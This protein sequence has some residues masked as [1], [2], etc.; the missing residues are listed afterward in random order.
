MFILVKQKLD[1]DNFFSNQSYECHTQKLTVLVVE[2]RMCPLDEDSG[3]ATNM[4]AKGNLSFLAFSSCPPS[5]S[6]AWCPERWERASGF[7][8]FTVKQ[9]LCT[10]V[11][12]LPALCFLATYLSTSILLISGN[13]KTVKFFHPPFQNKFPSD[14]L[15]ETP[16]SRCSPSPSTL[17]EFPN[18]QDLI[19]AAETS[20]VFCL[21]L[22]RPNPAPDSSPH[23]SRV[24]PSLSRTR[25]FSPSLSPGLLL[26]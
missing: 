6:C 14:T 13:W 16:C 19:L 7:L 17:L 12:F 21:T 3:D 5:C 1:A 22:K 20:P 25:M 8:K 4:P 2:K 24:H 26:L 10:V 9:Y 23:G 18:F 11:F 15:F